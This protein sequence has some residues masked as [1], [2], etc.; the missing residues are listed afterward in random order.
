MDCVLQRKIMW[1]EDSE[2][3]WLRFEMKGMFDVKFIFIGKRKEEYYA[4]CFYFLYNKTCVNY[5][6]LQQAKK[7]S[8]KLSKFEQF[9]IQW[10]TPFAS[11]LGLTSHFAGQVQKST[12]FF[13][14]DVKWQRRMKIMVM[15]KNLHDKFSYWI[16][17]WVLY[18]IFLGVYFDNSVLASAFCI[19]F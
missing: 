8:F 6:Q 7:W 9:H 15:T 3:R 11:L 17:K 18:Y 13:F 16:M 1:E 19:T 10:Y 4:G 5:L 2:M 12:G 14:F